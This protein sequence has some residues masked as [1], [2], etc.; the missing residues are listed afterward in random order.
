M[1]RF[2]ERVKT[3]PTFTSMCLSPAP[4]TLLNHPPLC[5]TL[6]PVCGWNVSQPLSIL[7]RCDL[8]DPFRM[9]ITIK[10]RKT[11]TRK[12][13]KHF[14]ISNWTQRESKQSK[15]LEILTAASCLLSCP[16]LMLPSSSMSHFDVSRETC[17]P[18]LNKNKSMQCKL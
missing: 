17:L 2:I 9:V 3:D 1:Y 14:Q 7:T 8:S 13:I 12:H 16:T 10:L 11:S 6:F 4:P 15:W 5:H 18:R